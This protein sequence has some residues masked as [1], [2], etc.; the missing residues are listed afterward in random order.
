[1]QYIL[2]Y[3]PHVRT[4]ILLKLWHQCI[5]MHL[6]P[7]WFEDMGHLRSRNRRESLCKSKWIVSYSQIIMQLFL[8]FFC[9]HHIL[10]QLQ[11]ALKKCVG[12]ILTKWQNKEA[13]ND[14]Y[15]SPSLLC[16]GTLGPTLRVTC[17]MYIRQ[18]VQLPFIWEPFSVFIEDT[19]IHSM[20]SISKN[21]ILLGHSIKYATTNTWP[22]PP[23]ASLSN[24][25]L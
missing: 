15:N 12:N 17:L 20:N 14:H 9:A 19:L 21:L 6:F 13:K 8:R 3:K 22:R 25:F 11:A 4:Q 5:K 24:P 2:Q 7:Y 18:K 10:S 23:P 16:I 1:M